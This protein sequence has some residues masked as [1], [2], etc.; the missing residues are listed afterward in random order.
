[1]KQMN[2]RIKS[3]IFTL[4]IVAL[5]YFSGPST[6]I[7][8]L[9][10]DISDLYRGQ[11]ATIIGTVTLNDYEFIL[12]SGGV[13]LTV[14][15]AANGSFN[16]TMP[17]HTGT[18]TVT[19]NNNQ[20]LTVTA[21]STGWGNGYG[22]D[23]GYGYSSGYG[24]STG[25]G[26]SYDFSDQYGYGYPKS[27]SG[28]SYGYAWSATDMTYNI[29]WQ[30]PSSYGNGSYTATFAVYAEDQLISSDVKSFNVYIP[31]VLI[32]E[33]LPN[34]AGAEP[35]TEFIELYNAGGSQ[36]DLTGWKLGDGVGVVVNYTLSGAINGTS[37]KL[38]YGSTTGI[39]LNNDADTVYL[40]D[41]NGIIVDNVSWSSTVD[42]GTSIIR[43]TDGGSNWTETNTSTPGSSNEV[44]EFTK[45][46]VENWNLMSIPLILTNGSVENVLASIAGN[47]VIVWRYNAAADNWSRYIPGGG[48]N[49][50]LTLDMVNG[51]WIKMNASDILNISGTEAASTNIPLVQ[52]WSLIGYPKMTA[53]TAG[54]VLD[55]SIA[56]NYQIVWEY[57]AVAGTWSRHVP[58]MGGNTLAN[59]TAGMAY[60]IKMNASDT[61]VI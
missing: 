9:M 1:M 27:G 42:E 20:E 28:Y 19:C 39:T 24:Y 56:G 60:W 51:Y 57:D 14:D 8:V 12:Q 7:T 54:T 32:N 2:K 16:C 52:N 38:Y 44:Q 21:A 58:G 50:L 46:L 33:V 3:L 13:L 35:A 53:Q 55:A 15:T 11:V 22:Y 23:I 48:S 43:A 29:L 31:A 37:F 6:A 34:P 10:N 5:L 26:Y 4:T 45:Q 36:V 40:Y 18:S 30:I 25:S 59:L 41:S 47:Y 17:L 49:T 61:L